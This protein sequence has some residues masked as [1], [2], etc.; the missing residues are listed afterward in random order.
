MFQNALAPLLPELYGQGC[1][2]VLARQRLLF[3]PASGAEGISKGP[4]RTAKGDGGAGE[5]MKMTSN[6]ARLRRWGASASIGALIVALNGVNAFAQTAD[7]P[8]GRVESAA[9]P[10]TA[11]EV[12]IRQLESTVADLQA[13]I[14]DLK[15]QTSA[16]VRDVRTQEAALPTISLNGAPT[17]ATADGRF[18]TTVHAVMQLDTAAYSQQSAGP[19]ATDLR[20]SGP[21]LGASA[22]NVDL[23]HARDLKD[24]TDFRRAR[25]GL[26]G[27]AFGDW[28]YRLT[29]DFAGS[30]V[31][32]T[33]QVYETWL[34]YS[35]FKPFKFRIGAFAPS[36]GLE[37][38]GSTNGMPF[39]ER[40]VSSD[41]ARGLAAGDTRLAAAIFAN[42]DHWLA[43]G[44]VTG[45]TV[46]VINTGTAAAVPQTYGDQLGFVGRLAGTPFYGQDWLVHVGVHG[47]YV[48]RP[49]NSAGP[50]TTGLT[51]IT[52]Y[53]IG[54]SN[55]QELRVDGTK[56]INTGNIDAKHA[57]TVGAEF[58][59]QKANF[60][61]QSEYEHFT[62]DRTDV[63]LSSPH[64]DGYYVQGLWTITGEPRKYNTGTAAFDAPAVAH[65]FSRK[66]GTW[67][68]FEFGVRYSDMNLNYLNGAFG[69]A[70]AAS[71]I[72][73]GDEK[74]VNVGL[75]WYLNSV[76]R[77]MLDY[78]HVRIDR[79][80]PNAA[81]YQTPT[82]AQIGQ[83]Y[84]A[85]AVR[86]QFAF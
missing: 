5:T 49:A 70:P 61:L 10:L 55:T 15:A 21:A 19:I 71:T 25:L 86:T 74:D 17:F 67:G 76:F 30:G 35:G 23:T 32:N 77:F 4:L 27:T 69:T 53:V 24:G 58:A 11:E 22:T 82:G 63:G 33:G 14:A 48:D 36:L 54:L 84:D 26:D 56:L 9:P 34:Q 13:A 64:F 7:Q 38:Q 47:S 16:A 72:R 3:A 65:P 81:L 60:L 50:A 1:D 8:L 28:N 2:A 42:G 18:S 68:A 52:N 46:G 44:A 80:S 83:S 12:R 37:D 78:D 57:G 40:S 41:L 45:R 62:V 29:L 6:I 66:D 51:P 39:L 75:N 31:E 59:V 85:V 20:R 79:L 73:G 43:S